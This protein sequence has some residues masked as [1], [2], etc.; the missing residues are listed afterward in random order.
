[1]PACSVGQRYL[2]ESE[3]I[4][5]YD[6]LTPEEISRALGDADL[7]TITDARECE[8]L[9]LACSPRGPEERRVRDHP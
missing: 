7:R 5:G 6:G 3:P 8:R 1:M 4:P 2:R 9:P